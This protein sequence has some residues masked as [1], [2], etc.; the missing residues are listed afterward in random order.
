MEQVARDHLGCNRRACSVQT[1]V[2]LGVG[3]PVAM[4]RPRPSRWSW[5]KAADE[6]SEGHE[7]YPLAKKGSKTL[8]FLERTRTCASVAPYHGPRLQLLFTMDVSSD[9]GRIVDHIA[10]ARRA[11]PYF[12]KCAALVKGI[13]IF[14]ASSYRGISYG[15]S[16][17]LGLI[18]D[19][20]F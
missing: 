9:N 7:T 14:F 17:N 12:M 3:R 13:K 16:Y 19:F 8:N 10:A 18:T 2:G 6:G 4:G 15:S 20:D 1:L 5:K 11:R